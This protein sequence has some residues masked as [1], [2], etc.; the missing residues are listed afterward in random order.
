MSSRDQNSVTQA[1]LARAHSPTS[2]ER[3][4][5]DKI[6]HRPLFLRP[7]SPP[8]QA[9]ARQARRRER[10]RKAKERK[11]AL[12]PKP[13]SA[14]QR[15]KLGLYDV[16]RRGQRYATYAPLHAL[17]L[18]YAREIL[19]GEVYTGGQGAAA[20]LSAADMHGAEVEVVRSGCVGRVGIRGIVIKDARFVFEVITPKNNIKIVPK[21]G[22]LF[23]VEIP[24]A[25][26]P[27]GDT[28]GNGDGGE[29]APPRKSLVFEIHGDQF[30]VRA[31]DRANKKFKTHFLN[32]I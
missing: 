32:K 6:Q 18:G 12:K 13:L 4:Y 28:D 30:A 21:E 23:R 11:K 14:S 15:R 22:T 5:T 20:K 8:P 7:T 26:E 10:E 1:L 9:T 24:P 31:A 2:A 17:W 25:E 29:K 16:P 3:I 27:S 19:G